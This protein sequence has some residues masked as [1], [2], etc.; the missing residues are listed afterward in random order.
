M[1]R[2]LA[3]VM[4]ELAD[5]APLLQ[6]VDLDHGGEQLEVVAGVA[7]ELLERLHVLGEAGAAVADAG[8]QE[9]RPDALVE[10]HA[11][12][13]RAHV[14]ADLL[15]DVGDLVDEGDLGGQE[16]VGGVLDH[17]RGGHAGAH[18]RRVDAAVERLDL[19]AVL[20]VGTSR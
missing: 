11:V 19:V 12:G 8:L 2:R 13:D 3:E 14:G 18:D 6:V 17:L 20:V 16:G 5:H 15:A 10:A 4:L 9:V 7:G 1:P